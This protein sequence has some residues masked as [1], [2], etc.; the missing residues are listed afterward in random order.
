M[1]H[2]RPSINYV[3]FADARDRPALLLGPAAALLHIERLSSR[4]CVPV[5]VRTGLE[6]DQRDCGSTGCY[7]VD[8]GSDGCRPGEVCSRAD[9]RPARASVMIVCPVGGEFWAAAEVA[10]LSIA[11]AAYLMLVFLV[12]SVLLFTAARE[13]YCK[14]SN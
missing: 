1:L 4:V 11:A 10:R 14:C 3:A 2:A 8:E 5:A 7:R 13:G 9:Q 12:E 6:G